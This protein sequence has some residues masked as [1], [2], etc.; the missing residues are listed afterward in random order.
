MK[1]RNLSA[2]AIVTLLLA[3]ACTPAATTGPGGSP[4]GSP[5]ALRTVTIPPG[6]PIHIAMWGVLSGPDVSLG[7]DVRRGFVL[8]ID[9][10]QGTLLPAAGA[11]TAEPGATAK[12]E[13]GVLLG[14]RIQES[15]QDA[16]CLPEGGATAA[17]R[18]VTETTLV[19]LIGSVCSD[20]TVG[21]IATITNSGLTTISP[22]NTRPALTAADRGP[23][24]AGYLRT[25]H[26][27]EIQG[28]V[29]ADFVFNQL[30]LTKAATIHDGSSYAQALQGV[31]ADEFKKLGGT[32]TI[33]TAVDRTATD[34]GPVLTSVAATQPEIIY[35]PIFVA[36]SGHITNQVRNVPG[37]EEVVLMGADAGFTLDMVKA[38]GP[39]AEGMFLSSPDTSAFGPER[40]NDFLAKHTKA[41]GGNPIQIFHAH[42]YDATNMLL[43]AIEA[44]A[45]VDAD[46]TVNVPLGALREHL[47][48]TQGFEGIT[49][50]LTCS[51]TGDCADP[52][53]AVYQITAD[54]IAEQWPPSVV[55][56]VGETYTP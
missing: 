55:W 11:A 53:I 16:S 29:A 45:T 2:V 32:V 43:D 50:T 8:A 56:R 4:G 42:A 12:V 17:Q 10:R 28:A 19:G 24:F 21:G 30:K 49:G 34:M 46:G 9:D 52:H 40:Y 1:L 33:Q 35:Y 15:Y 27:D 38:A 18:L 26:N 25:A 39:N 13:G 5:G 41:F 51:A 14:H 22:S 44:V 48:A 23:E 20:E 7:E 54:Q 6:E 37:L 3:V 31:F 36:P 47:F